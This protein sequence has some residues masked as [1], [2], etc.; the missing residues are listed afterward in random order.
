[1]PGSKP[2]ERRGGRQAGTP[3]RNNMLARLRIEDESDPIG[4]LIEASR[5]GV[6]QFGDRRLELDTD[7]AL[8]VLRELRRVAVPDARGV[9]FTLSL[10]P[11]KSAEDI[12]GA[13]GTIIA[14]VA[15]GK[16]T[17]DEADALGRLLETKRKA[18]ET[19]ELERRVAAMGSA[20][21]G[22]MSLRA[23]STVGRSWRRQPS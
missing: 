1:M 13:L 17:A 19:V 5:T 16:I 11:I 7:Q 23:A 2:G 3:N 9:A 20:A 14:E 8:G 4:K 21:G 15:A 22:A 12:D 10:P 6:L 18:I